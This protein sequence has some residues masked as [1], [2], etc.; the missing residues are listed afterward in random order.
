MAGVVLVVAAA[1]A[2]HIVSSQG[3]G[4]SRVC[5]GGEWEE[6]LNTHPRGVSVTSATTGEECVFVCVCLCVCVCV[7]V[8]GHDSIQA[9]S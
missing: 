8:E 7:C 3:G 2:T 6:I 1:S 4:E 9:Q 5:S